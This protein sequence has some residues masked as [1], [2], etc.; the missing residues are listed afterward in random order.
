M[1]RSPSAFFE[2]A[3][4]SGRWTPQSFRAHSASGQCQPKRARSNHCLSTVSPLVLVPIAQL[5]ITI[6]MYSTM[7]CRRGEWECSLR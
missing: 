1:K 5:P 4:L 7:I 6:D 2:A 3:R